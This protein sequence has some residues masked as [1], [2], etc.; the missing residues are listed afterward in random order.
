[1]W[2]KPKNY[3]TLIGAET[4]TIFTAL[5]P[6]CHIFPPKLPKWMNVLLSHN[7]EMLVSQQQHT[8]KKT[9]I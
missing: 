3:K 5:P 7:A 8:E 9:E 4:M 6:N 2:E 1:M